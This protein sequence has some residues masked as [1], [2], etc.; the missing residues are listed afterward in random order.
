MTGSIIRLVLL[1][2][3]FL[4][5]AWILFGAIRHEG[6]FGKWFG[7]AETRRDRNTFLFLTFVLAVMVFM[8]VALP[9]G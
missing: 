1:A 2:L 4:A 5:W 7:G 3:V 6:G 8:Q 9:A